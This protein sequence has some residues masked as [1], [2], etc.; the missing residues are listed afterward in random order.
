MQLC[1]WSSECMSQQQL[2]VGSD[3]SVLLRR[4]RLR[5]VDG[6]V[7]PGSGSGGC[8][9]RCAWGCGN[10]GGGSVAVGFDR[11]GFGRSDFPFAVSM[12]VAMLWWWHDG[13]WLRPQRIWSQRCS[14]GGPLW[15]QRCFG[16]L[17]VSG[18]GL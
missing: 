5:S 3:S 14:G 16:A 9:G 18:S 11:N 1:L 8:D 17:V 6:V 15:L 13:D 7:Y 12:A 4:R 10:F 2:L